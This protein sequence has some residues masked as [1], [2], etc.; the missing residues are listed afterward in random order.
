[1]PNLIQYYDAKYV[2][3]HVEYPKSLNCRLN[4]FYDR[5]ELENPNL[6]IPYSSMYKIENM[7]DKKISALRVVGLG[8]ISEALAIVGALWKKNHVYT[9]IHYKDQVD[10]RIIILDLDENVED[11]QRWIYH[12]MLSFRESRALVYAEK[13]FLLYE[14][15]R[16]GFRMKYPDAWIEDELNENKGDYSTVVEFA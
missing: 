14:N 8:L 7:D 1:M 4:V 16:Y 12:R 6:V 9:V 11:L 13:N 5:I 10:E 3:G 2:G 15:E